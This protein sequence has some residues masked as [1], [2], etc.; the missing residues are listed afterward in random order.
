MVEAEQQGTKILVKEAAILFESGS[1]EGLDAVI[2]VVAD[3]H[4]RLE[5]A[6]QKG[7]GQREEI[8]RRMATQWPQEKL[9]AKADYVLFNQGSFDELKKETEALYG[10]LLV[11]AA[12][13]CESH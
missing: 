11:A 4:E 1:N 13:A 2:V 7:M 9:M 10:M 3:E 6:V 8:M 12:S 5:R